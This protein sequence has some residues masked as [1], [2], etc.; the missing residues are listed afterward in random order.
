[1]SPEIQEWSHKSR[2]RIN[3]LYLLT[4]P[5]KIYSYSHFCIIFE[6]FIDNSVGIWARY[7]T[8]LT[9]DG[10]SCKLHNALSCLETNIKWQIATVAYTALFVALLNSHSSVKLHLMTRRSLLPAFT[11]FFPIVQG[12]NI[13]ISQRII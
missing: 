11:W 6:I 10:R 13:I 3:N 2:S 8:V 12:H 1:M 5:I 9:S 7:L 4:R